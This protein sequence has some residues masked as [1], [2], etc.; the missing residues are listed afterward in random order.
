MDPLLQGR[1]ARHRPAL[2]PPAQQAPP[3]RRGQRRRRDPQLRA[4][5]LGLRAR[6]EPP[7]QPHRTGPPLQGQHRPALRPPEPRRRRDLQPR[8]PRVRQPRMDQRPERLAQVPRPPLAFRGALMDQQKDR[9]RPAQ[10]AQGRPLRELVVLQVRPALPLPFPHQRRTDPW[11][12]E[13]PAW[14]SQGPQH[15]RQPGPEC[16][17]RSARCAATLRNVPSSP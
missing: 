1:Q 9:R 8:V 4:R 6:R 2:R 16:G 14:P 3:E 11:H 13:Q 7:G 5:P 17:A 15:L 10:L 12:R